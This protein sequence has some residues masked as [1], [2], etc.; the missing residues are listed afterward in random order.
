VAYAVLLASSYLILQ[1]LFAHP[2]FSGRLG[3]LAVLLGFSLCV[4][5]I[6]V[7]TVRWIDI[8]TDLGRFVTPP[9]RPGFESLLYGNPSA[10]AAA[11][12]L[13]W[14]ASAAHLGFG[15]RTSIAVL[16][17]LGGITGLAVFLTGSRGAWAGLAIAA[18]LVGPAW[19]LTGDHRRAIADMFRTRAARYAGAVAVVVAVV[20]TAIFF[21]SLMSRLASGAADL[22][23]AL[24]IAAWRMFQEDP[25]TGVGPG[26]YVVERARNTQPPELDYYVAHA[27]NL[28]VQALAEYGIVGIVAT[29]VA[30]AIVGRLVYRGIKSADPLDRRLGWAALAGLA[31]LAGHQLFDFYANMPAIAFVLAL[32]VARLDAQVARPTEQPVTPLPDRRTGRPLVRPAPRLAMA[33]ILVGA[34]MATVWSART[35]ASALI[36]RD[37]TNAANRGDWSIALDRARAAAE[38]EPEMPP[39]L[40]T[41]GLAAANAGGNEEA[42]DA[43]QRSAEMD[44]YPTSWLNVAS[45]E[46]G[47]GESTASRRALEAAMRL[48]RTQPQVA[49]G[50]ATLY[51]ELG[52]TDKTTS[53]VADALTAA[54][55]LVGDPYWSSSAALEAAWSSAIPM[56]IGRLP[57]GVAYLLALEA[58]QLDVARQI[59]ASLPD[60]QQEAYA[61]VIGAWTGDIQAFQ[62]VYAWAAA[63]PLDGNI[64][65]TCY[66]VASHAVDDLG[67]DPASWSCDGAGYAYEPFLVRVGEAPISREWLPGPNATWHFQGVYERFV[68]FDELVPGLPHLRAR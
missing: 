19:L 50:A 53:A 11:V 24:A 63:N 35:E 55:G 56:A 16:A 61:A 32:S 9:L 30:V 29:V 60:S 23:S 48:G 41:L 34:T 17:V 13:L 26:M 14:L 49:I 57:K 45:L 67:L 37:A 18:L 58:G 5:Y 28:F 3:S 7:V 25:V 31:Y 12:I 65:A 68:P 8:W 44:D 27:H 10:L 40:F 66:R 46:M 54:P 39:Y 38:S 4:A 64:V 59:V 36:A 1:R 15:T 6:A 52:D 43:F 2:Y 22:R 42:R 47:L 33:A 51:A 62:A 20:L 21:P